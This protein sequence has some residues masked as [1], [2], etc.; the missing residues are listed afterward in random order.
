MNDETVLARWRLGDLRRASGVSPAV[1]T[2]WFDR[3]VIRLKPYDAP[4]A[5][6]GHAR[7]LSTRRV[8]HIA[9]V[10]ELARLGITATRASRA[11]LAFT[12][13]GQPGRA[14]GHLFPDGSTWL[15]IAPHGASV[16]QPPAAEALAQFFIC[17]AVPGLP[18]AIALLD[19]APLVRRVDDALS[20]KE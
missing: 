5:G 2:R 16:I 7:L 1:L 6:S 12:D 9:I 11:A 15:A 14:P 10:A 20:S 8:Y 17:G 3:G 19:L 4:A 18:T 13:A